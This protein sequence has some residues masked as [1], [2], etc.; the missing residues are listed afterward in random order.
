M[1]NSLKVSEDL[2]HLLGL[3]ESTGEEPPVEGVQHCY[4][5]TFQSTVGKLKDLLREWDLDGLGFAPPEA[6]VWLG[7]VDGMQDDEPIYLRYVGTCA[8]PRTPHTRLEEDRDRKHGLYGKLND[9]LAS[10]G[11]QNQGRCFYVPSAQLPASSSQQLKDLNER[12]LIALL[13][14]HLLLNQQT[15]GFLPSYE[16]SVELLGVWKKS[17]SRFFRLLESMVVDIDQER[18]KGFC[19]WADS[20]L[21][22]LEAHAEGTGCDRWPMTPPKLMAMLRQSLPL[23]IQGATRCGSSWARTIPGRTTCCQGLLR[24]GLSHGRAAHGSPG[25]LPGLLQPR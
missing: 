12:L 1:V 17:Q 23:Q 3:T 16:P 24:V 4:L 10:G 19:T 25:K 11:W 9:Y 15:G 21:A 22:D 13:G 18:V 20:A 8:A 7:L 6:S 14:Q 2:I 5:R